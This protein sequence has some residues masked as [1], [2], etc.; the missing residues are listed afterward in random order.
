VLALDKRP[1]FACAAAP[2]V[3]AAVVADAFALPLADASVDVVTACQFLHHFSEPEIARLVAEM[4]RVARKRVIISDL[5]RSWVSAA[6]LWLASWPLGMHPI[7]R[8]DGVAS[9]LKGFVANDLRAALTH[10][11]GCDVSVTRRAAF[12]LTASWS[13]I[14]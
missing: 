2:G 3:N 7:T 12:R 14:H 8:H 10:A 11:T 6:G 1:L 4:T 9:V 13:P 5:R